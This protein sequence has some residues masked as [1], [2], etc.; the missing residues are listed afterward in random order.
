M[1]K[2]PDIKQYPQEQAPAR[3]M[4]TKINEV[5]TGEGES[6][7]EI[8]ITLGFDDEISLHFASP[9]EVLEFRN[10]LDNYLSRRGTFYMR[11]RNQSLNEPEAPY[12]PEA[13]EG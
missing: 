1:N 9:E 6:W 4:I 5:Y 3:E 10:R 7:V 8:D 12:G 2:I 11:D 13:P